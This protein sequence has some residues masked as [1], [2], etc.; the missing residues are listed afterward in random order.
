MNYAKY[1]QTLASVSSIAQKVLTAVPLQEDWDSRKIRSELFRLTHSAPDLRIVEGCLRKLVDVGLVK[2]VARDT[3]RR[4]QAPNAPVLKSVVEVPEP[5]KQNSGKPMRVEKPP[6][7]S[8]LDKLA[9]AASALRGL[10]AQFNQIAGDIEDA[11]LL[12]QQQI[13]DERRKSERFHQ[14]KRLLAEEGE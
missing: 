7:D 9:A 6:I 1:L 14:L 11:A 5:Q 2:E 13:Q 4:I 3:Y 10:A 12:A 8:S